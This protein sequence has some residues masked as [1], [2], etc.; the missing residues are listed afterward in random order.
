[1]VE[2]VIRNN[3]AL[4]EI[5]AHLICGKRVHVHGTEIDIIFLLI[6]NREKLIRFIDLM[7]T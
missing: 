4:I 5:N 7:Y 2:T 1:M 3:N 6:F